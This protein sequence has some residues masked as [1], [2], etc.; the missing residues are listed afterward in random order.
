MRKLPYL[1]Q[2]ILIVWANVAF[3]WSAD[4]WPATNHLRTA[5][6]YIASNVLVVTETINWTIASNTDYIPPINIDVGAGGQAYGGHGSSVHQFSQQV[7]RHMLPWASEFQDFK[8]YYS[9]ELPRSE[10]SHYSVGGGITVTVSRV[11]SWSEETR[12][13]ALQ[14]REA[15]I[16]ELY[17][18]LAERMYA[19]LLETEDEGFMS[20]Q[21][22]QYTIETTRPDF[23]RGPFD[24]LPDLRSWMDTFARWYVQTNTTD[25]HVNSA[26]MYELENA[27]GVDGCNEP[28][29]PFPTYSGLAALRDAV[30][31]ASDS[32]F[33]DGEIDLRRLAEACD[34]AREL[35]NAMVWTRLTGPIEGRTTYG[36]SRSVVCSTI[37][38]SRHGEYAVAASTA[39]FL[40]GLAGLGVSP[41]TQ[42]LWRSNARGGVTIHALETSSGLTGGSYYWKTGS[43]TYELQALGKYD[44]SGPMTQREE[45]EFY[46]GYTM[47]PLVVM[48]TGTTAI[49]AS[50]YPA[51][52]IQEYE[53]CGGWEQYGYHSSPATK[54]CGTFNAA[55]KTT[56]DSQ[57]GDD[58]CVIVN[59][60]DM[61]SDVSASLGELITLRA[62]IGMDTDYPHEPFVFDDLRDDRSRWAWE[63]GHPDGECPVVYWD[64][65]LASSLS[66]SDTRSTYLYYA[67]MMQWDTPNGF[68]HY[69]EP[70]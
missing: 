32:Y 15:W 41:A 3:G 9:P 65:G 67:G 56:I 21:S 48:W 54:T 36:G 70:R 59:D 53:P 8:P 1:V 37:T 60:I 38:A 62:C 22:W 12:D 40:A 35:L 13:I 52:A 66:V 47:R 63:A 55:T 43:D 44:M 68:E 11:T 16:Y 18:A 61:W 57:R 51:G 10:T 34:D 4:I 45:L 33:T 23:M 25:E 17:H 42:T 27:Y 2:F 19:V 39:E 14:A 28:S 29:E 50:G 5:T 69:G 46:D 20:F 49:P 30:G 58:S 6:P 31:T 64:D 24:Y 26:I 7:I